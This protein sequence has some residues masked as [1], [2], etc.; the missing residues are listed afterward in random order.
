FRIGAVSAVSLCW[1]PRRRFI[2]GAELLMSRQVSCA[3][4]PVTSWPAKCGGPAMVLAIGDL[5]TLVSRYKSDSESVYNTWF[6]ESPARLKAFRAIRRGVMEI[7]R[8]IRD[9]TFGND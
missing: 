1:L 2:L 5:A 4:L 9:G 3:C 6:V 7:V 8:T